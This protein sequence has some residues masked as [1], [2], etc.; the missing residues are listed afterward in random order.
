[1]LS[2]KL[3]FVSIYQSYIHLFE[4][5]IPTKVQS[6]LKDALNLNAG[7]YVLSFGRYV[8]FKPEHHGALLNYIFTD[9]THNIERIVVGETKDT[10]A[11]TYK[12]V[13]TLPEN[14]SLD[15]CIFI[16]AIFH[17]L[18]MKCLLVA[19]VPVILKKF[20]LDLDTWRLSK[21]HVKIL[22]FP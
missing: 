15:D 5:P 14:F 7:Q 3:S 2:V 1:M 12:L 13:G 4:Y 21:S 18:N 17:H 11:V 9:L 16:G 6:V 19:V 20:S 10:Y 8:D 22:P